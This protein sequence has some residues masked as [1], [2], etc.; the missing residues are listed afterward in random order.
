MLKRFLFLTV[1]PSL[2]GLESQSG[3]IPPP[4][5]R[6][7]VRLDRSIMVPMRDGV[8]LS[9]DLHFPVGVTFGTKTGQLWH[10][11]DGGERWNLLTGDLPAI[12]SVESVVLGD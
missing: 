8:K 1:I 5:P 7:E 3:P 2:G 12:W 6:Y 9:T 11:A 10:S 4:K